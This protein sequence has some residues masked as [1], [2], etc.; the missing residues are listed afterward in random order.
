M[1][2]KPRSNRWNGWLKRKPSLLRPFPALRME[3][4]EVRD[5]PATYTWTGLGANPNWS[6]PANWIASPNTAP[7]APT[8]M[9]QPSGS[10]LSYDD[11]VFPEGPSVRTAVNDILTGTFNSISFSTTTTG[12][13]VLATAAS[14]RICDL[15]RDLR[16]GASSSA[17]TRAGSPAP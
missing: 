13:G 11:L 2:Q 10:G 7:P 3:E 16:K 8:G 15:T 14:I 17:P 4:L 9:P 12:A 5:V 1:V 6:L